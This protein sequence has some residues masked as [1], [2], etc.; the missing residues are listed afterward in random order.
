[1]DVVST[2]SC[3]S[4]RDVD[5]HSPVSTHYNYK[6]FYQRGDD[7]LIASRWEQLIGMRNSVA[8]IEMVTW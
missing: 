4:G 8:M 3:R 2:I 1:M 7:W 5:R 6:N